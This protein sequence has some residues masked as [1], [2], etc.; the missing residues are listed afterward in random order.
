MPETPY[1]ETDAVQKIFV[2][3]NI[4]EFLRYFTAGRQEHAIG[5]FPSHQLSDQGPTFE[6]MDN[7]T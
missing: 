2:V 7:H 3:C 1:L 5:H 6:L 4:R